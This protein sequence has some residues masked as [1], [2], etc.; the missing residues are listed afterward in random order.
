MN[1]SKCE[2]E[3][4]TLAAILSGDTNPEIVAHARTCPVCSEVLLV[5]ESLREMSQLAEHEFNALPDSGLIWRKAQVQ[6]RR[7][8][9]AKA[10]LPIRIMRG[11]AAALAI[12]ASPWIFAQLLHPLAWIANLSLGRF[13]WIE[14][15]W[16]TALTG[17]T[18]LG[19]TATFACI[20]AG[21]W[22]MLREK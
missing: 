14:G 13:S 10:T 11:C 9:L 16:L 19:I 5:A 8:T 6:V 3:P 18:L 4:R 12:F 22:Y 17:T 2:R 15:S 21:S 7:K 1:P 20:A